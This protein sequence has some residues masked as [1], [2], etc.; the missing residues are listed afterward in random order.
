MCKFKVYQVDELSNF[1][2]VSKANKIAI[3]HGINENT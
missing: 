3:K 2:H 1:S